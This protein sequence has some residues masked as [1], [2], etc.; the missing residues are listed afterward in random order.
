MRTFIAVHLTDELRSRVVEVQEIM[1]RSG[2]RL[3]YV[4]PEALHFTLVFLG[5]IDEDVAAILGERLVDL[6]THLNAFDITIEGCGA[7]PNEKSPRVYWAG[8]KE[9]VEALSVL[10][11][12]V[13]SLTKE[14]GLQHDDK[15]KAH[16]TLARTPDN[17]REGFRI[18]ERVRNAGV[19]RMRVDRF[20]LVKS[21]LNPNGPIYTNLVEA[22]FSGG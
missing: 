17:A 18:P 4:K 22:R 3:R 5:E 14:L 20:C 11:K 12:K 1:R 10:Q 2:G 9:G 19:G 21:D 16:L 8:V 6:A 15:F 7:F 13:S